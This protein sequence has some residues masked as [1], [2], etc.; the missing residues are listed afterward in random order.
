M[1]KCRLS[2]GLLSCLLAAVFLAAP[3]SAQGTIGD[4]TGGITSPSA[5]GQDY[6]ENQFQDAVFGEEVSEGMNEIFQRVA[7]GFDNARR[8]RRGLCESA[9]FAK[10]DW[11]AYEL[12]NAYVLG[13][14][15]RTLFDIE[16]SLIR[17]GSGTITEFLQKEASEAV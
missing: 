1:V 13:G 8:Q 10:A 3:A 5:W 15:A 2:I 7:T 4:W 6:I 12:K 16:K 17:L 9:A 14:A 11:A